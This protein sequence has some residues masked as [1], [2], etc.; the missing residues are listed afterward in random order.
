M[1]VLSRRCQESVV[2]SGPE[3]AA[4]TLK[5]TVLE[6]GGG[7]VRLGFESQDDI[8]IHRWEA[9]PRPHGRPARQPGQRPSAAW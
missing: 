4:Y 1:Q 7:M 8:R 9:L 6:F 5:V 2:V 3:G